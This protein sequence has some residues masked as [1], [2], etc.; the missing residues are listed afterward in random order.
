MTRLLVLAVTLVVL[1]GGCA[2]NAGQV[3]VE[4]TPLPTL[5]PT[6]SASPS[7]T[8]PPLPVTLEGPVNNRGISD[9]A[10]MGAAATQEIT[11]ADFAFAPTF[12]K[13]ASEAT[14]KVTL[15]NPGGLA[16][17]TFTIDALGFDRRLKPGEQ[18]DFE[19]K[20]PAAGESL[21]FYCRMHVD[22]GMQG[23]IYFNDGEPV[24]TASIAP[25]PAAQAA[26]STTTTRRVNPA[27]APAPA[28]APRSTGDLDVPDL[29]ED[30]AG[31]LRGAD[32]TDGERGARG[33]RGAPGVDPPDADFEVE[34]EEEEEED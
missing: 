13:V 17:H 3:A 26:R 27:P 28:P 14:L 22:K 15:K 24:S 7:P 2:R 18:A 1:A 33:T 30:E 9:L 4:E 10:G 8:E 32:G 6:P 34:P 19:I 11:M 25:S 5:S 23:A 20:L 31:N 29:E 21:R 16:D 12:I